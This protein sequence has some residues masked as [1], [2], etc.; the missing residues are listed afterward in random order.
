MILYVNEIG[1]VYQEE[2]K[3]QVS[4]NRKNL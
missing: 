4:D 2:C 3:Q 1:H